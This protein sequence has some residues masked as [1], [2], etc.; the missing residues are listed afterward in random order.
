MREALIISPHLDD[1]ALSCTAEIKAGRV[2]H[3]LTV[4]AGLPP[5]GTQLSDWERLT[6]ARDS[7]MRAR[8]RQEEDREAW[9][10]IAQP[11]K[12]LGFCEFNAH[13][14]AT[15][16]IKAEIVRHSVDA[17]QI[18][19]P[20][21]IGS[22]P[23]HVL[24]RDLALET[25]SRSGRVLTLYGE[26][27]YVA[28]YGWPN[29]GIDALDVFSYWNSELKALRDKGF[30]LEPRLIPLSSEERAWKLSLL[31]H[32]RSQVPAVSGGSLNLFH[33]TNLLDFELRFE[34]SR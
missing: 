4:F 17:E 2:A 27:P 22:H 32:Y 9:R 11:F 18:L 15:E 14:V 21:G 29:N 3:V 12:Q 31:S 19:L 23:H 30:S 34:L 7:S 28:F 8:E 24:V 6:T 1:A 13:R 10:S 26:L 5:V 33:S 20:A 16:D 25:L